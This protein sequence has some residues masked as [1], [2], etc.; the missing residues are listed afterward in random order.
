MNKRHS[1]VRM[2]MSSLI[3]KMM[4]DVFNQSQ[5]LLIGDSLELSILLEIRDR[6]EVVMLSQLYQLSNLSLRL[7]EVLFL[8]S[9]NNKLL[10]AVDHMETMDVAV[11]S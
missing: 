2:M 1:L 7:R 6:V 4:E 11:A 9:L 5:L 8:H 3:V 10:I